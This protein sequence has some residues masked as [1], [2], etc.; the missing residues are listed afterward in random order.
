[1]AFPPRVTLVAACGGV[2]AAALLVQFIRQRVC[3]LEAKLDEA[4][5]RISALEQT[6]SCV[7]GGGKELERL[8]RASAQGRVDDVRALANGLNVDCPGECGRTPL[9][10]AANGVYE[11]S[12]MLH[13]GTAEHLEVIT[14]LLD[15]GADINLADEEG[16]TALHMAVYWGHLEV[17]RLLLD[18]GADKT[19]AFGDG[20]RPVDM[21]CMEGGKA[22][23]AAI[24]EL[25]CSPAEFQEWVGHRDA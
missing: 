8:R 3:A 7:V 22:N 19:V 14:L 2:G 20:T 10:N 4:N 24:M 16:C 5:R 9:H 13:G 25:L 18:K 15:K 23:E 1:M 12:R 17:T 11:G 6:V 21:V